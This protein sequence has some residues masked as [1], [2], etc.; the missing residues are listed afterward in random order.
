MQHLNKLGWIWG[1][2]TL[3]DISTALQAIKNKRY[4]SCKRRRI[5][6]TP[7]PWCFSWLVSTA[8]G[9]TFHSALDSFLRHPILPQ[10]GTSG[11]YPSPERLSVDFRHLGWEVTTLSIA[12]PI[13]LRT[14]NA[15][16]MLISCC[17]RRHPQSSSNKLA[18]SYMWHCSVV[19][20]KAG[21]RDAIPSILMETVFG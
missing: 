17:C 8:P 19:R 11:T 9:S 12:G 15:K 3:A 16:H 5:W 2:E 13:S 20:R 1:A 10:A 4:L 21:K 6:G 7:F 14:Y 18:S